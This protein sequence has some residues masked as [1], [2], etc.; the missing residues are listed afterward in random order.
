MRQQENL[1]EIRGVVVVEGNADDL[2]RLELRE[3]LA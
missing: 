3:L 2:C 1:M